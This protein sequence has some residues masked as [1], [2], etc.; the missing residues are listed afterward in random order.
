MGEH[1]LYHAAAPSTALQYSDVY[2]AHHHGSFETH[3]TMVIPTSLPGTVQSDGL[4]INQS[5][6]VVIEFVVF[7]YTLSTRWGAASALVSILVADAFA[8]SLFFSGPA[9]CIRGFFGQILRHVRSKFM[10]EEPSF[11]LVLAAWLITQRTISAQ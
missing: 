3:Y 5:N 9:T 11:I 2:F 8:E 1:L 10:E 7:E 6:F 4:P